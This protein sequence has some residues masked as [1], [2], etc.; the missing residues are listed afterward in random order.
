MNEII[1]PEGHS[2]IPHDCI[3]KRMDMTGDGNI[4]VLDVIG[5][6]N[7]ILQI[8]DESIYENC[9]GMQTLPI[10]PIGSIRRP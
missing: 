8:G 4:N 6:V 10:P 5:M 9:P 7:K 1:D 3:L 2:H